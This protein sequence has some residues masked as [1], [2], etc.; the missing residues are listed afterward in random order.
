MGARDLGVSTVTHAVN[1]TLDTP[2]GRLVTRTVDSVLTRAEELVDKYIPE[3]QQE[4]IKI[5]N[6]FYVSCGSTLFL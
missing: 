4:G 3:A 5:T 1:V 2:P 6:Y